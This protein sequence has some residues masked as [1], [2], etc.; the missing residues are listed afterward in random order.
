M[1]SRSRTPSPRSSDISNDVPRFSINSNLMNYSMPK[2][3]QKLSVNM[4]SRAKREIQEGDTH[5]RDKQ[6]EAQIEALTLQNVK[7][8]RINRLLKVDTDNL[9]DQKTQ[10]LTQTIRE[11]TLTNVKLQRT[12][13]LLEQDLDEKKSELRKY[14]E[15][16]IARMKSV[17][18]EYEYLVQMVNLLH[19]Q[20]NGQATCDDTCC[21]TMKPID[22]STV[23]MTLPPDDQEQEME[24][25]HICR[26]VIHSSVSQ[27]SYAVELE[28]KIARLEHIIEELE[29]EKEDILRQHSYKDNDVEMLKQELLLKDEIV[30]QLEQDFLQLENHLERMKLSS[31]ASHHHPPYAEE[32]QHTHH[33]PH[34][35]R[36][37]KRQSQLLMESKRRSLAIKDTDM[38]EHMLR[39]D[40][41]GGFKDHHEAHNET[42]DD[43]SCLDS[44]QET[45]L[46]TPSRSLSPEDRKRKVY[47]FL[48]HGVL[49]C[50]YPSEMGTAVILEKDPLVPLTC[51]TFLLGAAAQFG[52][53]DDWTVP[54]T[55]A[56]VVSSFLWSGGAAGLQLN[57]K[58]SK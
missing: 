13:R 28:N 41:V 11:L 38:L 40:L 54:F 18:P 8:M 19:R 6:L 7:L 53:T 9:I 55:L 33:H 3:D 1:S 2:N 39:G 34:T 36:D 30:S 32:E 57:F 24:A 20:I 29:T 35:I 48:S 27:G 12:A 46:T 21:Y 42:D 44:D 51:M 52:I 56:V 17:G 4:D 16:Q 26:P 31:S 23:V 14:Q 50:A 45:K 25:Q 37:P 58:A 15:E 43:S 49:P 5:T 10:P 22:E 47:S